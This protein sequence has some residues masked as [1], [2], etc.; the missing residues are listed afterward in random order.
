MSSVRPHNP[1]PQLKRGALGRSYMTPNV[2]AGLIGLAIVAC[3]KH[4]PREWR[5]A[6]CLADRSC[7]VPIIAPD[8]TLAI[9]EVQGLV[10]V[11]PTMEPL[12]RAF[13]RSANQN[14]GVLS[15]ESGVFQIRAH[16][17]D[18]TLEVRFIGF[19]PVRVPL[20]PPTSSGVRVVVPMLSAVRDGVY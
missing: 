2:R 14:E 5:Y 13:I 11:R 17:G 19:H 20:P 15:N 18:D 16:S 10:V 7:V 6:S 12:P 1:R 3:G 8:S 4:L 9:G